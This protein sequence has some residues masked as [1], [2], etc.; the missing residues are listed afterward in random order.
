[1]AP[2]KADNLQRNAFVFNAL[3]F[4]PAI[5]RALNTRLCCQFRSNVAFKLL[6]LSENEPIQM[7]FNYNQLK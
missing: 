4:I 2:C 5:V 1:M 7:E 3:R 6:Q